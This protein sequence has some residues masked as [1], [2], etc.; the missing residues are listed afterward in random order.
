MDLGG[1]FLRPSRVRGSEL[2]ERRG[3]YFKLVR[4]NDSVGT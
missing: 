3:I 4:F 1:W 2:V